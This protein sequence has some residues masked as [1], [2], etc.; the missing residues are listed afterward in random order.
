MGLKLT[1]IN[2]VIF[3]MD[4]LMV[5]TETY[6]SKAFF[7]LMSDYNVTLPDGYFARLV[8]IAPKENFK[9]IKKD[10]GVKEDLRV[11]LKKRKN[12]YFNIIKKADL[13]PLDGLYEIFKITEK[14]K[15]NKGIG[16]SSVRE[17]V[18]LILGL[19]LKALKVKEKPENFFDSIVAGDE[20]CHT[21]PHPDIYLTVADTLKV[22]PKECLVLEDS[23]SGIIAAKR[24][25]MSCIG[26]RNQYTKTHNLSNADIVVDSLVE[27]SALLDNN[28][29]I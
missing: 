20:V 6:Q 10:F 26:V 13:Q 18:L 11:M 27:V 16:S 25:G 21:K 15:W 7:R 29:T 5:D 1:N 4:G 28:L 12:Y 24:A 17:E 14:N 3:D 9:M 22:R 23:E 19:L 2:T 8:G